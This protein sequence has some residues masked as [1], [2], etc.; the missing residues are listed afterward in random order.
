MIEFDGIWKTFGGE[1]VL[2]GVDLVVREGETL[3]LLGPSGTGKSV[4]LKHAIGLLRPD[5]GSVTVDGVSIADAGPG[6][7]KRVRKTVGYVFQHAALFD[8]MTVLQNLALAIHDEEEVR[9]PEDAREEAATLLQRVNLERGVLDQ[10]PAELSGGM[11][12]RVGVARAIASG[13]RYVLYD[14]PTTGLDPVNAE[15]PGGGHATGDP[16]KRRPG[17]PA[18]HA[19]PLRHR[20]VTRNRS[21]EHQVRNLTALG[22]LV[23]VAG[24]LF[25][26]GFFFLLGDPIGVG[27]DEVVVVMD[28]GAGLSRGN[29]VRL[30]GVQVGTVRSVSLVSPSRVTVRIKVNDELRLPAD[31]RALVE[32]DVFGTHTVQLVPGEALVALERGDT[33]Q[34]LTQ[35]PLPALFTELGGQARTLMQSADSLLSPEAVGDL[36][37]TASV[38]PDAALELRAAF[39]ELSRAA[40]SLRRT[41]EE[42]EQARVGTATGETMAEVR[43]SAR[44]ANEAL[45]TMELSL[46]SL[47]SVLGKVDRGEGT[48]GRLVNDTTLYFELGATLREMRSLA[49]DVQ[50]NPKRYITVE[51]F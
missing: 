34:G 41:A 50:Q 15:A 22:L 51:I 35:Q 2:R 5:R 27:G 47:A 19:P 46:E 33:I 45:T 29:P 1:P 20:G 38:L 48:L 12:K 18:V 21:M 10:F 39:G 44:A 6:Q 43:A 28:D 7:L 30:N 49:A 14:E 40:A 24:G 31:T 37:A 42:M 25:V 3:V 4:L 13:P 32:S 17:G 9:S 36:K 26:W 16:G 11:R 23:L 8:S